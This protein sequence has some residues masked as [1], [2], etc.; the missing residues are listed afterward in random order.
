VYQNVAIRGEQ[1]LAQ[2]DMPK[3]KTNGR[4]SEHGA[5]EPTRWDKNCKRIFRGMSNVSASPARWPME[6]KVLLLDDEP[7]V[8]WMH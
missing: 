3:E 5:H 8:H 2:Q 6:P 7:F 1:G 4:T